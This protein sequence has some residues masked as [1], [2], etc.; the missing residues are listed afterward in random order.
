MSQWKGRTRGGLTG[1]KIFVFIIRKMGLGAAYFLCNF[2]SLYFIVTARAPYRHIFRFY[3]HAMGKGR[4]RSFS[5]A[6]RNFY[7]FGTILIDKTALLSGAVKN[8]KLIHE[9]EA[10]IRNLISMKKGGIVLNGHT[11]NWEIAGHLLGNI[12]PA[13]FNILMYDGE[14]AAVRD[15]L[16]SLHTSAHAGVIVIRDNTA[17]LEEIKNAL[18]RC[19]YIA[20]NGDRFLEGN[21]TIRCTFMGREAHF[22]AGPFYMA[23]KFSVPLVFAFSMKEKN[24]TYRFYSSEPVIVRDFFQLKKR[25]D[26]LKEA[27]QAFANDLERI[28]RKYP[29]QWFN[30]YDFWKS[31]S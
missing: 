5:M 25:E 18:A 23:G 6:Y 14:N 3:R 8:F 9:G 11:G 10:G 2:V 27:A 31:A 24:R 21:K 19:E 7:T 26:A 15:Y 30:Y 22:P 13:R 29:L 4:L 1:H 28:A 20:M 16:Q 12:F 17:H